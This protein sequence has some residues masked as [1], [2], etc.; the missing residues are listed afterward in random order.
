MGVRIK[1]F[2]MPNG[3]DECKCKFINEKG[4]PCCIFTRLDVTDLF[5]LRHDM[6]PLEKGE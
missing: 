1:D 3:C 5:L 6:C 2:E 4:E